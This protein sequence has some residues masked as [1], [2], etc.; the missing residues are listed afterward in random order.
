MVAWLA[1]DFLAALL[2]LGA[3]YRLTTVPILP[4]W[5]PWA[6]LW[7]LR[8]PS[9]RA[10]RLQG[11]SALCTGGCF[12]LLPPVTTNPAAVAVTALVVIWAASAAAWALSVW[13]SFQPE[14]GGAR[15]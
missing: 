7:P 2:F 5:V 6:L 9:R 11:V 3:G 1:L 13:A 8:R 15:P 14:P 4:R 10:L 12:A